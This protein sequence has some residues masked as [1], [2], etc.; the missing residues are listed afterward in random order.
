MARPVFVSYSRA[1][2]DA[3]S[4]LVAHME[5]MGIECWIAPRDIAPSA[6]WAAEIIDAISTARLM[7]L[8]FSINSN[9]SPQVRREVERAVHK[10][11]PIL[12]FRIDDVLPEKSLEYFLSAQHWLDA[13]PGPRDAYYDKLFQYLKRVLDA[14]ATISDTASHARLD[15]SMA[16]PVPIFPDTEIR[17]IE[18]HLA[19]YLGPIA[20]L[21]VKRAACRSSSIDDLME[22]L[23]HEL[24]TEHDRRAFM[25]AAPHRGQG[26]KS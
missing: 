4:E 22:Q 23:A 1:D 20:R 9:E 19:K 24:E 6:E 2:R 17:H 5:V 26:S 10:R 16:I 25:A 3:A 12:A 11:V 13:F 18:A 15:T 8:V 7:V 21:L 14:P